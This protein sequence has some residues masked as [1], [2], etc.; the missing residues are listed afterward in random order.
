MDVQGNSLH[1]KPQTLLAQSFKCQAQGQLQPEGLEERPQLQNVEVAVLHCTGIYW[2][3]VE[4]LLKKIVVLL[5]F[6]PGIHKNAEFSSTR[7]QFGDVG[8][9][10]HGSRFSTWFRD[11]NSPP[12]G[13]W[14]FPKIRIPY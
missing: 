14:R 3:L 1:P 10:V 12:G 2:V 9:E 11:P 5:I 7:A 13:T 6:D 4:I 8:F